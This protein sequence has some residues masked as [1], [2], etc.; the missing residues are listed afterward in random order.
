MQ[1]EPRTSQK[2][3]ILKRRCLLVNPN[4]SVTSWTVCHGDKVNCKNAYTAVPE[5]W[6]VKRAAIHQEVPELSQG[7]AL[8]KLDPINWGRGI[9]GGYELGVTEKLS[10]W[11]FFT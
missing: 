7:A 1:E 6:G 9:V 8:I 4:K 10:L 5:I 11:S 2:W 3:Y